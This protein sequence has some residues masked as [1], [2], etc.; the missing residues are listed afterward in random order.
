MYPLEKVVV[1]DKNY[2]RITAGN[3]VYYDGLIEGD[4]FYIYC[5]NQLIGIGKKDNKSV[6]IEKLL[7]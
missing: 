1:D 2:D 6:K 4:E 5:K 3:E 7:M